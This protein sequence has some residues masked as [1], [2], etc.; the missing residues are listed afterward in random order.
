M[1][2]ELRLKYASE[3]DDNFA[4]LVWPG[5]CNIRGGRAGPN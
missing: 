4:D 5:D 3:D 1:G 2:L